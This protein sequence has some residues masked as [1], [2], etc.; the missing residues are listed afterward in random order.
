MAGLAFPTTV[1]E[2]TA[3]LICD[4]FAN[5]S[6]VQAVLVVNSCARGVA[7]PQSDL[8]MAILIEAGSDQALNNG[9]IG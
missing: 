7:T 5:Q 3:H 6:H 8:D 9:F 2:Q 1:H 4:F